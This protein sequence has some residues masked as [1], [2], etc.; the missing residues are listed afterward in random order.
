MR[1]T[2]IFAVGLLFVLAQGVITSAKADTN[3]AQPNKSRPIVLIFDTTK[4]DGADKNLAAAATKALL[5]YF[6][7]TQRVEAIIFERDSPIVQRAIMDKQLTADQVASYSSHQERLTAAKVLVCQYAAG[8]EISVKDHCIQLRLWLGKVD[9]GK[10]SEWESIGTAG[11]L[12]GNT[13]DYDNAL[14]SAASIA[15]LKVV[16]MGLSQLPRVDEKEPTNGTETTAIGAGEIAPPAPPTASDY[17]S[18]G[19]N[20]LKIGNLAVAIQQYQQA[21]NAD[22]NKCA[23][24]IELADAYA[25]KGLFEEA[26][27]ELTRAEAMNMDAEQISAERKRIEKMRSGQMVTTKPADEQPSKP[28]SSK[29]VSGSV[30]PAIAKIVEGDKLWNAGK[31]DDAANSYRDAI[32]LNPSDWRAYERLAVVDASMSL[33]SESRK[34]LEQLKMIQPH[35]SSDIIENRYDL[36]RKAFDRSFN[37]LFKQYDDDSADYEKHIIS[38]ESYYSSVK[39]LAAR[40]DAM[41]QFLDTVTVPAARQS[42]N[43]HRSLACGLVAQSASC[44]INY[45]ETNNADSKTNAETFIA[46]ARKE[47]E[48]AG[49][50]EVVKTMIMEQPTQ[51]QATELTDSEQPVQTENP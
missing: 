28:S 36:F 46:Q 7:E 23:L 29:P 4:G 50:L 19:D 18:Q 5:A 3:A 27:S 39:G 14:Q 30:A 38:R 11:A 49:K 31:P 32:K 43:L 51:P 45:L 15:V 12:N 41:T 10:R 25:R 22:P 34:A 26:D 13:V 20:S 6:R 37:A 35:P 24:R 44:L 16:D 17:E 40:L 1:K 33:F 8:S 47:L 21:V 48:S 42:A 9:G 2:I